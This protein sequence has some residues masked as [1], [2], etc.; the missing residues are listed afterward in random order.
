M[1]STTPL[2]PHRT[3]TVFRPRN[4]SS[5]VTYIRRSD[6]STRLRTERDL[7]RLQR[8][9][10][11]LD[12]GLEENLP[13]GGEMTH[14]EP[15]AFLIDSLRSCHLRVSNGDAARA[16]GAVARAICVFLGGGASGTR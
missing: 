11:D 2:R 5:L 3:V 15:A 1:T 9:S 4:R 13:D 14:T 12:A 6:G 10:A 7:Q 16:V 8:R